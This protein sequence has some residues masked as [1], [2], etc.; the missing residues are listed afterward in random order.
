MGPGCQ[1]VTRTHTKDTDVATGTWRDGRIGTFRGLRNL[2]SANNYGGLVFGG[3]SIAPI[4]YVGYDPLLV[5][6]CKFF[7]TGQAPVAADETIEMF[8]FMEAADE[9]KRR[10]GVP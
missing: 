7:K 5:E 3:K 1:T 9:S 4:K 6:I 10:G 8:A 2:P